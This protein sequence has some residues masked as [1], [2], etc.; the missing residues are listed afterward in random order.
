M[1][2]ETVSIGSVC[3]KV[4][5]GGTPKSTVSEYY[6]DGN[7][8]WLNTKEISFNRIRNT[9]RRITELGLKNSS[10]KWVYPPAVIIAMYGVTAGNVATSHIPLTTN[11]ACCN[12]LLDRNKADYRFVYYYIQWKYKE[13]S[14]LANGGAQ[15]NLNARQIKDFPISLPNLQLQH[16]IADILWTID[17]K[18]EI[19]NA[20]N[21]NLEEQIFSL[22]RETI[23]THDCSQIKLEDLC[24]FQEGY[25]NPPQGHAE[26]FDGSVKWL[27]A[28]DINESYIINTSR[29]LTQIGFD[30]AKKS[31]LL[32]EPDTIAISK[33][34]TI[35]RLGL[36]GDFMCGNRAVI[37]IKPNDKALLTFLYAFLKSKQADFPEL[38]VGS[39]Q[40]NLYVSILEPLIVEMPSNEVLASLCKRINSNL[41]MIKRN[42][43]ENNTL[44]ALR[45]TLLPRLMSG[46]I[47][48]SSIEI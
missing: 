33:S 3:E 8:P 11:Q 47:D 39:V 28:V 15:Q 14:G 45:D 24:T 23:S 9:E 16:E 43:F 42:C 37:N 13:I 5:S 22:Y 6:I 12:L 25:V 41:D 29:T 31:A 1:K 19:N 35:G 44:I 40:K 7:I 10:A 30:S 48:I 46:E 20:I 34:G 18:I 27:R 4:Y 32:F 17:D 2:S 38:A 26:Y 36:I 21:N